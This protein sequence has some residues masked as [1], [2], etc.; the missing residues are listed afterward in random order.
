MCRVTEH[1][2][3]SVTKQHVIMCDS[4]GLS[5]MKSNSD[6][7]LLSSKNEM[8]INNQDTQNGQPV[9]EPSRLKR[10]FTLPRNPIRMS[11]RKPKTK[12][13]SANEN[14]DKDRNNKK[15]FRTPSLRKIINKIAQH[16]GGVPVMNNE[17]RV[18]PVGLQTW[19]PD[20][21]PG[22]TGL[23]NHGN[24]CFINAVIQCISHTDVLAEYFVL[25]RY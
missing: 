6:G 12:E 20:E 22:V 10:T 24:T 18:P 23:R 14:D 15:I 1:P 11:K 5:V 21:V 4:I 8:T 9:I 25:D 19:G 13:I 3:L 7:E 17:N 16:I 2:E